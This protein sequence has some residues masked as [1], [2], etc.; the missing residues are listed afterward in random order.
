MIYTISF[1]NKTFYKNIEAQI[2]CIIFPKTTKNSKFERGNL[3]NESSDQE[4]HFKH[5]FEV[6]VGWEFEKIWIK[7]KNILSLLPTIT[8][9]YKKRVYFIRNTHQR[10]RRNTQISIYIIKLAWTKNAF[11]RLIMSSRVYTDGISILSTE[12]FQFARRLDG[13]IETVKSEVN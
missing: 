9:S 11:H 6:G 3:P 4:K 1:Y 12:Y 2:W 5:V 10:I 7:I 13:R 8:G